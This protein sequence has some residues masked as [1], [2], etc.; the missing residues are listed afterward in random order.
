[1]KPTALKIHTLLLYGFFEYLEVSD[2]G[3]VHLSIGPFARHLRIRNDRLREYL[4][5]LERWKY[6]RDKTDYRGYATFYINK[7]RQA[8]WELEGGSEISSSKAL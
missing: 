5:W 4:N 3:L 2:D 7:P 1:M 6:I 8:T